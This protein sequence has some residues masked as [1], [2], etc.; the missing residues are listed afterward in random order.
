MGAIQNF[1]MATK[2][3]F[4]NFYIYGKLLSEGTLYSIMYE[5]AANVNVFA[6]N[7]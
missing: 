2:P 1:F 4:Y 7:L 5:F 6:A 3:S